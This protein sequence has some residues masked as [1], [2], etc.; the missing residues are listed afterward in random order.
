MVYRTNLIK[1]IN[2]LAHYKD[3]FYELFIGYFALLILTKIL[4]KTTISQLS[5]F[6]FIAALVLGELVG[7]AMYTK[8]TKVLHVLFAITI[9]GALIYFTAW[10]TQKFRVTRSIFEGTPQLIINKGMI[11]FDVLKKNQMDLD[12]LSMGLRLKD[13]F[14]FFEVEY[15]FLEPNGDI[16]VIKKTP[17]NTVTT[18]DINLAPK[19]QKL[20]YSVVLDGEVIEKNLQEIQKDKAWLL[21]ELKQHNY[22]DEKEIFIAEWN[23]ET[24]LYIQGF[25]E[26]GKPSN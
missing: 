22:P 18:R 20:T 9:W 23:E 10:I 21:N 17:F 14:S 7:A 26:V 16:S 3:I 11:V 1:E 5:T 15:A 12:Q 13:A 8:D 6:D 2:K 4:G 19:I 25:N 24:G